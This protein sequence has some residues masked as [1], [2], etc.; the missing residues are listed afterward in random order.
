MGGVLIDEVKP[1]WS[2]GYNIHGAGLPDYPKRW[3]RMLFVELF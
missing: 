2:L 1:F 3:Q